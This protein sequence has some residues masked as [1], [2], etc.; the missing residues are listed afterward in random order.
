[1]QP[2]PVTIRDKAKRK[3]A[4]SERAIEALEEWKKEGQGATGEGQGI[5]D[6]G[7]GIRDEGQGTRGGGHAADEPGLVR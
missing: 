7:Q 3:A 6:E 1:M 2:A 4:I 5:R